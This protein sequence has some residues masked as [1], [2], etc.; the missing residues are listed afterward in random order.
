[1]MVSSLYSGDW[2]KII[3]FFF[4]I[5]VTKCI[6]CQLLHYECKA[7]CMCMFQLSN[8]TETTLFMF[9]IIHCNM[10]TSDVHSYCT[11]SLPSVTLTQ[12]PENFDYKKIHS[13]E[14]VPD[15]RIRYHTI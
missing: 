3:H 8:I 1:M 7:L 6:I 13:Q 15:Y 9:K 11:I 5:D 2:V 14:L 4:I 12:K 10:K